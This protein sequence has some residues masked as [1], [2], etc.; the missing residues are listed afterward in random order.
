MTRFS[1]LQRTLERKPKMKDQFIALMRK[2]FDNNHTE[3]APPLPKGKECWYLPMFGVYHP[4]KPDQIRVVFDSSAQYNGTSLNN[5]LLTGPDL[6]NS[7]LGVL[8]RFRRERVAVMADIEQMF[9][10]FVMREDQRDYLRFLWYRDND[11]SEDIVEYRMRVHVFGNSPSPAVATY[12]LRRAAKKGEQQYESDTRHFVGREFYVDDGLV[13]TSTEEEAISLL[14]KTQASLSESNLRLHKITSNSIEV[15]RAFPAGD[16]AKNIKDLDLDGDTVPTQRSLGL[17]W[18]V[19]TDTFTFQVSA[20]D[21]PFTRRGVLSTVNSLF[22]PLGFVA[23]VTIQG[24]SLLRELILDGTDWDSPLPQ[25]KCNVWETWRDSLQELQHLHIPRAYTITSCSNASRKEICIFSD[26]STKAIC[27][28]A[29]LK[30]T[31][32]NGQIHVG[33]ILGKARLAPLTEPTIPRLK[34]CAAVLAVEMAELIVQEIDIQLD[35]ITFYCDSK[36][37]LGYIYNQSKRFYV[38]VHNRVQR[39]RQS[40]EPSQWKY[41]PTEHNPA[42]HASRSVQ[43][44]QLTR[45]N[46]LTGPAFLYKSQSRTSEQQ[47]TFELINPDS[48]VEIRP[49]VTSCVTS[50]KDKLLN[51]ERFAK[52]SSWKSLQRAAATLIHIVLSFKPTSQ[53]ASGCSGWHWCLKPLTADELSKVTTVIL[54]AVQQAPSLKN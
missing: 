38:Y 2:I 24:K 41:V 14:Q 33:F 19:K 25:D 45:T 8:I 12:C 39:I 43:A 54:L 7:L 9:Y 27:A 21:K 42:D 6:N 18:E 28:V 46:W 34:L 53:S 52:F 17:S 22:D 50:Q 26:A 10:C 36:V 51:P 4:K 23:P 16:H 29:Y 47:E 37:V 35:A 11:P 31:D 40:T 1:S 32:E 15:L 20:G 49:Q 13:S 5:V 30:T 44:S 48:D 3:P